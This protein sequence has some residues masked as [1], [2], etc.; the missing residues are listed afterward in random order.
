MIKIDYKINRNYWMLS[1][2]FQQSEIM[3]VPGLIHSL[4]TASKVVAVRF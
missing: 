3:V 4:M 2:D 1:Y